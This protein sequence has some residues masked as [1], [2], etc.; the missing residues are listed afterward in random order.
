MAK[1]DSLRAIERNLAIREMRRKDTD[2]TL[3][4]IGA[5]FRDFRNPD[6]CISGTRVFQICYGKKKKGGVK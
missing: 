1:W 4:Q 2:L 3:E 6:K 5:M